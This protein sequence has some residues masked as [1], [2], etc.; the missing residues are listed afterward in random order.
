DYSFIGRLNIAQTVANFGLVV[1]LGLAGAPLYGVALGATLPALISNAL[2]T[3]RAVANQ[4]WLFSSWSLSWPVLRTILQ[5]GGGQWLASIGWQ[6]AFASDAV[7]IGYL[8]FLELVPVFTVT[9]RLGLTLM[10]LSWVLPD[11][12]MVGLAQLNAEGGRARIAE[13]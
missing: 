10:Q 7:V 13:V 12:S 1:G 9:S 4:P 2:L 3:V 11:S 8:G 5:S 6:L